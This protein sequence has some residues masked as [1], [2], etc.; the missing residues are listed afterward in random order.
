MS[1]R[2]QRREERGAREQGYRRKGKHGIEDNQLPP[3]SCLEKWKIIKNMGLASQ[4]N[5]DG[6]MEE[7]TFK[8]L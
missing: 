4:D 6:T 7:R 5:L 1:W 8:L 2:R 3:K